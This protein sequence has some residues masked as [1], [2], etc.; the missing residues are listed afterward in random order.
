MIVLPGYKTHLTVVAGLLTIAGLF[1]NGELALGE[2]VQRGLEVFSI[3][4]LRIGM[5][6][7]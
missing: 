6:G 3:S 1:F 4:M 2:A 7:S 5:S